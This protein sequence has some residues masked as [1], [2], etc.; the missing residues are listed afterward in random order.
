M[1]I[2]KLDYTFE[3]KL[4]PGINAVFLK[5]ST[6]DSDVEDKVGCSDGEVIE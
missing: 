5:M 3:V 1:V 4:V 6:L 2:E